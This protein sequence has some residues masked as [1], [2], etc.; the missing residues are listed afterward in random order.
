[1]QDGAVALD[2]LIVTAPKDR[3]VAADESRAD[4]HAAF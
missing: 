1:M 3:A 2:T 4:G